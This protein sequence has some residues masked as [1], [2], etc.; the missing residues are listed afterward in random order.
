M[1]IPQYFE[2]INYSTLKLRQTNFGHLEIAAIINNVEVLFLVDTG[3][4]STVIDISFAQEH[5]FEIIETE[6]K[7]GGVGT[8]ELT[9]HQLDNVHLKL[10]DFVLENI[11]IYAADLQH[12]KQ[13]LIERGETSIPCGVI[14]A[15]I[16]H[17]HSAVIDYENLNLYLR[18]LI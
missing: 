4:A 14:G 7:G 13:S 3:A 15:D 18:P 17:Q 10:Y 6:I 16:L 5:G 2:S 1:T 12:V 11:T 8:S 9:I